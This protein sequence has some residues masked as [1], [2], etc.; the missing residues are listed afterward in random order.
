M[1]ALYRICIQHWPAHTCELTVR[2]NP[3]NLE[4]KLG[5]GKSGNIRQK[6]ELDKDKGGDLRQKQKLE[7]T[8]CH[9][10]HNAELLGLLLAHS[11][12]NS[13][14]CLIFQHALSLLLPNPCCCYSCFSSWTS[15][16]LSWSVLLSI[17]SILFIFFQ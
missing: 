12:L 13:L 9:N 7:E 14:L 2:G 1:Q 11:P 4:W 10:N 16:L 15:L 17:N 3:T 6:W 8:V 5:G